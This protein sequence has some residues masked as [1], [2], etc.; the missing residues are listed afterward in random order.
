MDEASRR[1]RRG[2]HRRL[3]RHRPRRRARAR[4]GRRPRRRARPHAGRARGARRRHP[5]ERARPR[6]SCRSNLKDFDAL[7]RLGAAIHERWGKLD[8]LLG[9]AGILGELAP[10]RPY[11]PAG[12]GR[13]DGG[14]RHRELAADPL[15]RPAAARL[16]CR[17][18]DLRVLGR[19][20]QMHAPIGAPTRSRRRRSKRWCAPTR[21]RRRRRRRASCSSTRARCAP[22][23][24]APPM[25]GEDPHDA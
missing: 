16:R 1:P 22:A 10:H 3:A 2:R 7:D 5:A 6:R 24:A 14:Q 25:P 21:P 20:P 15:P 13:R 19:R 9:N 17:P 12:L 4:R 18:R 8:I 23:C 11:R